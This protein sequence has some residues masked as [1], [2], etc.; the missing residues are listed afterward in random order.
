LQLFKNIPRTFLLIAVGSAIVLISLTAWFVQRNIQNFNDNHARIFESEVSSA[1]SSIENFLNARSRL[2]KTFASE[3]SDQ[4]FA[5]LRDPDNDEMREQISASLKRWFPEHFTFTLADRK[6][7]DLIRDLEGFVGQVCVN[8][9]GMF[10]EDQEKAGPG[11]EHFYEPEIH[12]QA[13]NY[14][15]DMMSTWNHDGKV[16]GV[17]F[18]SF[19]PR[20]IQEILGSYE[21]Q[22]HN[23]LLVNRNRET[24]IEVTSGGAR[25]EIAK[26]REINL[27]DW[28]VAN[29]VKRVRIK[30]SRW[31]LVA[32]PAPGLFSDFAKRQWTVGGVIA[33][34]ILLS[35]IIALI[36]I[37]RVEARRA[38]A[39][40]L[41]V[42]AK[43]DLDMKVVELTHSRQQLEKQATELS[44]LATQET[45]L[46][47]QLEREVS[48]KDR[49]FSIISHDLKSPFTSILG[50]SSMMSKMSQQLSKEQFVEYAQM[51][52][53][54][55][56]KVFELLEN[57]LEWARLQMDKGDLQVVDID[58]TQ[59][60]DENFEV[61]QAVAG[62]KNINLS[63]DVQSV[64][65]HAERNMVLLVV[66]NLIANAIKFTPEGGAITVSVGQNDD[67]MMEASV[68]DT[69]VGMS[70]DYAAKLFLIDEKTTTEGTNGE[71]GTGL[72]LPLCKEMIE[73]NGGNLWVTTSEGEGST[74][75]FTLP[76]AEAT[77]AAGAEAAE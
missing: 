9:I 42:D 48:I 12:P 74:F 18:V 25:N 23:L 69:G 53:E 30:N 45:I 47:E 65:A 1:V 16:Q 21:S 60:I 34:G 11:H 55:G 54:N 19:Y 7:T 24:L 26:S 59:I 52:H 36:F 43:E 6:G 49:F 20:L 76:L 50:L 58:M 41:L 8:S 38:E 61:F 33:L 67:G 39:Q 2:I 10:L 64:H 4:L 68:S 57:L 44:D 22:G 5:L 29:A 56:G 15:F 63:K 37:A 13:F 73:L 70:Q 17:F 62:E 31:D 66:R 51:I 32:V 27:T 14:H 40:A 71:N 46:R 3:K 72:G 35:T 28:E 77:D 75:S